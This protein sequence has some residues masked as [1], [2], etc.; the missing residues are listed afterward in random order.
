MARITS[1]D[2]DLVFPTQIWRQ[3]QPRS[4][5]RRG[6]RRWITKAIRSVAERPRHKPGNRQIWSPRLEAKS[7]G[8]ARLADVAPIW[9]RGDGDLIAVR[10]N[11]PGRRRSG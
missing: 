1:R 5:W 11:S 4:R 6:R 7:I 8:A 2:S 9:G 10:F 3:R